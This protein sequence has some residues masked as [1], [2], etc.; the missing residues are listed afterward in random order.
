MHMNAC[1][2]LFLCLDG[3]FVTMSVL[4]A[5]LAHE[6]PSDC[7][8]ASQPGFLQGGP[9]CWQKNAWEWALSIKA[10]LSGPWDGP[11]L[12]FFTPVSLNPVGFCYCCCFVSYIMVLPSG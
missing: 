9:G 4:V 2:C 5:A 6:T 12:Y 7:E 3:I 8:S 1:N 11:G 10:T